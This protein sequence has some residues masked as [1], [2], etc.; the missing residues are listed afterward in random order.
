MP[1]NPFDVAVALQRGA[2]N[3]AVTRAL[4]GERTLA[5]FG[6]RV[7]TGEENA[8]K[9][10]QIQVT[11]RPKL[12]L[13]T[14]KEGSHVTAW[15][16]FADLV[17]RK[18]IG[19]GIDDALRTAVEL[20]T[21]QEQQLENA[22][23][24]PNRP[25]PVTLGLQQA[26]NARAAVPNAGDGLKASQV[27]EVIG[28]Y[29]T[30]HNLRPGTAVLLGPGQA[31]G[32][33]EPRHLSVLRTF[34][35]K[36]GEDNLERVQ[37][38]LFGL[39]DTRALGFIGNLTQQSKFAPGVDHTDQDRVNLSIQRGLEDLAEAYPRAYRA[40]VNQTSIDHWLNQ[41][42]LDP[43]GGNVPQ[44]EGEVAAAP[45]GWSRT[46]TGMDNEHSKSGALC[47]LMLGAPETLNGSP[48]VKQVQL[49][50]RPPT[51]RKSEQGH[52]TVSWK[53]E[54]IQLEQ[55]LV[56]Y[57][58]QDAAHNLKFLAD[59][60]RLELFR[61]LA[62]LRTEKRAKRDDE[63][64]QYSD[65]VMMLAHD[66]L[67]QKGDALAPD[68]DELKLLQSVQELVGAYM[69]GLNVVPL[70][71]AEK[72]S[73]ANSKGEGTAIKSL[74]DFERRMGTEGKERTDDSS[75]EL[76]RLL[77]VLLDRG[78]VKYL[79]GAAQVGLAYPKD[80]N[81]R[82]AAILR[83][84]V[85]AAE[86]AFPNAWERSDLGQPGTLQNIVRKQFP[87]SLDA[88]W[89]TQFAL[90]TILPTTP[91]E[92]PAPLVPDTVE[93]NQDGKRPVEPELDPGNKKRRVVGPIPNV[94]P[95]VP[96]LVQVGDGLQ[97]PQ[98]NMTDDN[99]L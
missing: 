62:W 18:L 69:R 81:L 41:A 15:A 63:Q 30:L 17:R 70:G 75:V 66:E 65:L 99:F 58:L 57:T 29:L 23:Q 10:E 98:E 3:Q 59:E 78:A 95:L 89:V 90:G 72:G 64:A 68:G 77:L 31:I 51:L 60:L 88:T 21:E 40:I 93:L 5:R 94:Q 87:P 34:E 36:G 91:D 61:G 12:R 46:G 71:T 42:G 6:V 49:A 48:L 2:G 14:G 37:T 55:E 83:R 8:P 85:I 80:K 27:Q 76:R 92:L 7:V 39:L 24:P 11:G 28:A 19:L 79:H 56:G 45:E 67:L 50:G 1:A 44:V 22:W 43:F 32:A 74:R 9:V 47:Q 82:V 84:F 38:A 16:V 33:G 86:T 97:P 25:A 54:M 53:L 26:A 52:H 20:L 73:P 35:V 96:M 13:I 4:S